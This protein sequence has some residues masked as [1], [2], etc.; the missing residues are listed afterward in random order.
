[1]C[2]VAAA[3]DQHRTPHGARATLANV[4]NAQRGVGGGGRHILPAFQGSYI[5]V[6]SS[7]G[8]PP[9]CQPPFEALSWSIHCCHYCGGPQ[10]GSITAKGSLGAG[11]LCCVGWHI[12]LVWCFLRTRRRP[13]PPPR[14]YRPPPPRQVKRLCETQR[15]SPPFTCSPSPPTPPPSVQVAPPWAL[16]AWLRCSSGGAGA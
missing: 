12:G 2:E 3:W 9:G 16:A 5:A 1:M 11:G 10:G 7:A 6:L 4:G 14:S 13:P 15:L 8:P